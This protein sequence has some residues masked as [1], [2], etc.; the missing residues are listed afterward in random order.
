MCEYLYKACR[1]VHEN[2][3]KNYTTHKNINKN[4]LQVVEFEF[5][6][7]ICIFNE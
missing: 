5:D 7:F 4:I 2:Y 1:L 6:V 3:I